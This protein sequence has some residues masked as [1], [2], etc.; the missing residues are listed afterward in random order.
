[1]NQDSLDGALDEARGGQEWGVVVLFRAFNPGLLRY[2]SYHVRGFEE[3]V[4]SEVLVSAA[5]VL[6]RFRGDARAFRALLFTL[7]RRRTVDHYR[8]NGR[9]PSFVEVGEIDEPV[10]SADPETAVIADLSAREAIEALVK[11]LPTT[12]AEVVLLRVV[13]DLSVDEVAE[14][15]DRSPGSVRVI[16]HRALQRLARKFK[17]VV[18]Q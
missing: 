5:T 16:Q 3:D 17:E 9:Q 7:A 14:I 1:M 12:Q 6:P 15:L 2:L 11:G 10:D 13:G 18:T 4:A 8:R